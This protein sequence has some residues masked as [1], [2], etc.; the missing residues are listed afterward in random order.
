[1]LQMPQSL[2][3]LSW[4]V[5]R[6]CNGGACVRVAAHGDTIVIGSSKHLDGPVIRYSR[7]EWAAFVDGIRQGDFDDLL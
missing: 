1:M 6:K 5:A 2:E 4:R 7:D 3:E